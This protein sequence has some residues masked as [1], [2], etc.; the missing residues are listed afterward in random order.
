MLRRHTGTD[1][2]RGCNPVH[3]RVLLQLLEIGLHT[4]FKIVQML[5]AR[6]KLIP[7]SSSVRACDPTYMM[8]HVHATGVVATLFQPLV[9]QS[10]P[11]VLPLMEWSR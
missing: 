3:S 7:I 4:G 5:A 10:L 6:H 2:L 11:H 8:V 9:F 1:V